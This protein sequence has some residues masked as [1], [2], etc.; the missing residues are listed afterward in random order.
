MG[1]IDALIIEAEP[2]PEAIAN[3]SGKNHGI[4]IMIEDNIPQK[5]VPSSVPVI[6]EPI[7]PRPSGPSRP[8]KLPIMAKD[9]S[10]EVEKEL[11]I[12]MHTALEEVKN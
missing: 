11:P 6:Y 2:V 12:L 3:D 5:I 9:V 1:A 8:Y 4:F 10:L 7:T